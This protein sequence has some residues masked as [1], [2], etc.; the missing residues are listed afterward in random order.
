MDLVEDVD[1]GDVGVGTEAVVYG[2]FGRN[3]RV[4]AKAEDVGAGDGDGVDKRDAVPGGVDERGR[5]IAVN[6][7][8]LIDE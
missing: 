4:L 7:V 8:G 3:G 6:C 1:L 5:I 2:V